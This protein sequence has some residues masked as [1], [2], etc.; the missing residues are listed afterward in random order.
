MFRIDRR[1]LLHFDWLLVGL[2]A[3]LIGAGLLTLGSLVPRLLMRQLLWLAVGGLGVLVII[4]I[5]YRI[6]A[7]WAYIAYGLGLA[8]LAAVLVLGRAA[9][10]ARRWLAIG[11]LTVQPSELFKLIIIVTVATH[12]ASREEHRPGWDRVVLPLL[13]VA[14]AFLLIVKQPD[15]GTALVLFPVVGALLFVGGARWR[16]LAILAGTGLAAA[17]ALWFFLRGYQRERLLVYVD[18]FRDPLGSA[19]NVI[20]AK[21]TIGSGQLTGKGLFGGT[22]S[23]LAFLPERHTDFIFAAFAES[24]GFVGAVALLA[25]YGLLAMRGLEVAATA[26]DTLGSLLATGATVLLVSQALVNIG[27]VTGLLPIVGIPLPMVSYGGSALL[28]ALG[29]VALIEN[30]R[31]RRFA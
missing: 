26:R 25:V 31:M 23:R 12:L 28:T 13:L 18:P 6:L 14:P 3:L 11:P 16:D 7:R 21:I 29:A 15:L 4:S 24:W 10:G 22:Q 27:M 20:Q 9:Q 5:D 1:L 30:V 19:W 8:V 17:P 2:A